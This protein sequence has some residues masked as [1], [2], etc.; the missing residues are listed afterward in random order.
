MIMNNDKIMLV[1]QVE[2]VKEN[3]NILLFRQVKSMPDSKKLIAACFNVSDIKRKV[4]MDF[5]CNFN[6][7]HFDYEIYVK[8]AQ[9]KKLASH[10]RDIDF[11]EER[12]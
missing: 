3:S 1:Y 12:L 5:I 10:A 8:P 9:L 11:F 6:E 2:V 4:T 7:E